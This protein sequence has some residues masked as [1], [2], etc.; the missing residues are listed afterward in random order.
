MLAGEAVVATWNGIT[1]EGRD[2]FYAW[3]MQEH[4]PERVGI[5]G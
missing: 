4:I 1:P 2:E 5:P 3:H